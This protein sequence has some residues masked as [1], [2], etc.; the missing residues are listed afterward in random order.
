MFVLMSQ[1]IEAKRD[2]CNR[3]RDKVITYPY[4]H[5]LEGELLEF[6]PDKYGYDYSDHS[7]KGLYI[8]IFLKNEGAP[9]YLGNDKEYLLQNPGAEIHPAWRYRK[10]EVEM[11]WND[12]W[13]SRK[14][15]DGDYN[16]D[17]HYGFKSYINSEAWI[18]I[19]M[20]GKYKN[21]EG[22]ECRWEYFVKIVAV[23]S[24]S[25]LRNGI[26][27]RSD[28]TEIGP[29]I[30]GNFAKTGEF[31]KNT[32][33]NIQDEQYLPPIGTGQGRF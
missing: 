27:Y 8:N 4:G 12:A 24:H 23:M 25:E 30:W 32:C 26:W 1:I 9:P 29:A 16:L 15:C 21:E 20:E 11:N 5:R 17:E 22:R 7:F 31:K 6:R 13:L 3:I 18:K 28:E 2:D 19:A 33:A 10:V 14:D